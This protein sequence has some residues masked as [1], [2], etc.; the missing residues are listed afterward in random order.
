MHKIESVRVFAN[1]GRSTQMKVLYF[2][3]LYGHM[4][5]EVL[6]LLD[7]CL[8]YSVL[9]FAEDCNKIDQLFQ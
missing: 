7:S 5:Y 3:F 9:G 8:K 2:R 4:F 1:S 6:F